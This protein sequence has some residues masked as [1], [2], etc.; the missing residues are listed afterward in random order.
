M[1]G[2]QART[3]HVVSITAS[4]VCCLP[5]GAMSCPAS[6]RS[7]SARS[8]P[9]AGAAQT[10]AKPAVNADRIDVHRHFVPP[11]YLVDRTRELAQRTLHHREPAR[12]HGQQ[13]RRARRD[14]DRASA[15][16]PPRCRDCAKFSRLANEYA[17][18]L[19]DRSSRPLRPVRL[20]PVPGC[21]RHAEG[22]RIRP[23]YAEGRR[24]L[25]AHQLRRQRS[26]AIRCS[27]RSSRSST[28]AAPCST[29]I[30]PA[31]PAASASC[32]GCATPTSSTAPTPRVRSPRWCSAAR[33]AVIPTCA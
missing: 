28:A 1:A 16:G 10:P 30:R 17:A 9:H 29:P 7:R 4:C 20:S 12:G 24:R 21:R 8:C 18:K 14:V 19:S 25:P 33:R 11:G 6:P 13:R 22:D 26:S 5:R 2:S 15:L 23:R 27:R 31:I 3:S 32:R